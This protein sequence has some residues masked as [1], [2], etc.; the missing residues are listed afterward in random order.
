MLDILI[1][2][3]VIIL[4]IS[5]WNGLVIL[6]EREKDPGTKASLKSWWHGVGL[7]IRGFVVL[8]AFLNGGWIPALV[9]GFLSWIPYNIIISQIVWHKWWVLGTKGI[10]GFIRKIFKIK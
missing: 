5:A 2:L 1:S 10:D 4:L 7:A 9:L 8:I 3:I 6:W